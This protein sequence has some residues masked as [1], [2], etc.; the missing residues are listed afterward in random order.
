MRIH[1]RRRGGQ[2]KKEEKISFRVNEQ[3]RVPEVRVIDENGEMLGVLSTDRAIEIARERGYDLVEVSPK[4]EPPVCKLLDYGQF[5]YQKEKE[6]RAQKAHS[7]KVDVKGIR[8]SV[9]MGVGDFDTRLQK[10]KEFLEEGH[11]LNIEIRLRGREK[12]HTDIAKARIQEYLDRLAEE[13]QLTIEQPITRSGGN[14]TAI[15]GRKD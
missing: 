4:A 11:K 12:A 3:I 10:G 14:V 13:Y 9:K 8:L 6:Q 5:K 1:H 7:K 2:Y 15:V